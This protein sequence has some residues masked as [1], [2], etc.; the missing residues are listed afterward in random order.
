MPTRR[1]LVASEPR[2]SV[3]ARVPISDAG[4]RESTGVTQAADS[5]GEP[6]YRCRCRDK[7]GHRFRGDER[8]LDVGCG[9]RGVAVL[10]R[11]EVREVVAVDVEASPEWRDTAGV[12]FLVADA[13]RLPFDDESF[14]AIHSKDS[15]HHMD[16]PEAALDEYRRVLRP[17]GLSSSSRETATTR[18]SIPA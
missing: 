9:D 5:Q 15:L 12:S 7:A 3:S 16:S 14:D 13:Q 17:G 6:R 18:S 1:A 4:F 8:I 10:L 2:G 11:E